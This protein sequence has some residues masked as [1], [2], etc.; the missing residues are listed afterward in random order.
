MGGPSSSIVFA[1]DRVSIPF[2]EGGEGIV[3]LR[4]NASGIDFSVT[5]ADIVFGNS[6]SAILKCGGK[7]PR[8]GDVPLP[9]RCAGP[10]GVGPWTG[11]RSPEDFPG[12]G[13]LPS[14][15]RACGD[16]RWRGRSWGAPLRA[17]T[18]LPPPTP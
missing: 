9:R 3:R 11:G 13:L 6:P 14:D 7:H 18:R 12:G 17:A 8:Y 16:G 2:A 4:T 1:E 5:G 10:G 15:G